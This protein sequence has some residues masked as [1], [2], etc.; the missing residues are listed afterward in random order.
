MMGTGGFLFPE[1]VRPTVGEK[2][3][4]IV[5]FNLVSILVNF[6]VSTH[7]A[8]YFQKCKHVLYIS[9]CIISTTNIKYYYY[10]F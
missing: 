7:G 2:K 8:Y 6:V 3:S 10:Y 5:I 9:C 1:L 4:S